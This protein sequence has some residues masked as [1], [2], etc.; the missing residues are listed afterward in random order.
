[1]IHLEKFIV[2]DGI[3]PEEEGGELDII[4]HYPEDANYNE[5][6]SYASL[7]FAIG[8]FSS[9]L[10]NERCDYIL[11]DNYEWSIITMPE[12]ICICALTHSEKPVSRRIMNILLNI[13]NDVYHLFFGSPQ[14]E[15]D[16]T[17]SLRDKAFLKTGFKLI[18]ESIKWDKLVFIN[19]WNRKF[20]YQLDDNQNRAVIDFLNEATP[21]SSKIKYIALMIKK[22]FLVSTF[23]ADV[24]RCLQFVLTNKFKYLYPN[25]LRVPHKDITDDITKEPL[26]W[27]VGISRTSTNFTQ[28]YSP[29]IFI[30]GKKENLLVMKM[31]KLK[32][33]IAAEGIDLTSQSDIQGISKGLK[34]K[35]VKLLKFFDFKPK[36]RNAFSMSYAKI[37][38]SSYAKNSVLDYEQRNIRSVDQQIVESNVLNGHQFILN[39]D[40]SSQILF[41][42]KHSF[43]S[44]LSHNSKK[45][46][47]VIVGEQKSEIS[48]LLETVKYILD[49]E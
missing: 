32:V 1:M 28:I 45:D 49:N 10:I 21:D 43:Y 37:R 27:D 9:S 7:F 16:N 5:L 13:I 6:L 4:W 14:R 11:T 2:F 19:L 48:A 46:E 39:Y 47:V 29:Q 44:Y 22:Q 8:D 30:S 34:R 42:G 31:G 36:I 40:I 18:V 20:Q 33:I 38:C 26:V 25:Y 23:P 3:P 17:I 12:K 15:A 41:P 24:G 35:I